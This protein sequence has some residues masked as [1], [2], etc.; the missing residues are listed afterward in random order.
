MN[1]MPKERKILLAVFFTLIGIAA[2]VTAG[3]IFVPELRRLDRQI[4]DNKNKIDELAHSVYSRE[5]LD[6]QIETLSALVRNKQARFYKKDETT[7]FRF[8]DMIKRLLQKNSLQVNNFQMASIRNEAMPE[9]SIK[10]KTA[11]FVRFIESIYRQEKSVRIPYL[12]INAEKDGSCLVNM[13]ISYEE[14]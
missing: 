14:Y 13:R 9:F 6:N 11:D 12:R 10:G 7:P 3:N 2:I 8:A 5:S 4:E 1:P